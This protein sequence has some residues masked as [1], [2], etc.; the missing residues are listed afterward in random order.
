M[1]SEN[2]PAYELRNT[3]EDAKERQYKIIKKHEANGLNKRYEC[4]ICGFK[5][6]SHGNIR[7]HLEKSHGVIEKPMKRHECKICGFTSGM[8]VTISKHMKQDHDTNVYLICEICQY[9]GDS[10]SKI[11]EH[12]GAVHL[13]VRIKCELC[14]FKAR[15]GSDIQ[16]HRLVHHEGFRYKCPVCS[17]K[18]TSTYILKTH[19]RLTHLKLICSQCDE[20][21]D[22]EKKLS[23]H[24]LEI[25][26]GRMVNCPD[27]NFKSYI[28]KEM[29]LHMT[30]NHPKLKTT[31][32]QQIYKCSIC[33]FTSTV[34]GV[35]N[36][37]VRKHYRKFA[38]CD[39]CYFK[40]QQ[41][42]NM[43][44]HKVL[45]H[46]LSERFDK[47]LLN[48]GNSH[49]KLL[50]KHN[51]D[52]CSTLQFRCNICQFKVISVQELKT[53]QRNHLKKS[54]SKDNMDCIGFEKE[55]NICHLKMEPLE[56][57]SIDM[58]QIETNQEGN[59]PLTIE[60]NSDLIITE[61]EEGELVK[62]PQGRP[63][64]ELLRNP[65]S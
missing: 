46:I 28:K 43:K 1:K 35:L 51:L 54:E 19:T 29:K 21:C 14:N 31:T 20:V 39:K 64:K 58:K 16:N 50:K 13:K 37:H 56:Q 53:H 30:K 62:A 10:N 61:F 4:K 44:I 34:V 27:C 60:I 57:T 9:K 12:M 45:N 2:N 32:P 3:E 6:G 40:T 48:L 59:D 65:K 8:F 23:E 15:R 22:G 33:E 63:K 55:K 42:G 26:E 36:C 49:K 41:K 18:A 24:K 7:F 17:F 5:A 11:K 25:H 38:S 52:L 47:F